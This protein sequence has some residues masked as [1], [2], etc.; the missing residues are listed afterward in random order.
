MLTVSPV[1]A[2]PAE[3]DRDPQGCVR[4]AQRQRQETAQLLALQGRR[5]H[6]AET[7][8]RDEPEMAP[9]K[10]QEHGDQVGTCLLFPIRACKMF[11]L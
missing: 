9:S 1:V 6:A 3:R 7:L 4:G 10:G 8:G 5:R 11:P 2:G